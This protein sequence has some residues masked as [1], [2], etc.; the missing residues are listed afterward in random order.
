MIFVETGPGLGSGGMKENGGR[1]AFK[2]EIF[3]IL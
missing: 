3:A 1:G 2:Y